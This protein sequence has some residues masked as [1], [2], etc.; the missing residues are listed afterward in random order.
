M[1]NH[2]KNTCVMLLLS[3]IFLLCISLPGFSAMIV[4]EDGTVLNGTIVETT[5]ENVI[6]DTSVGLLEVPQSKIQQILGEGTP[7]GRQNLEP[8]SDNV[9][10]SIIIQPRNDK[11]ERILAEMREEDRAVEEKKIRLYFMLHEKA[12][13]DRM[14]LYEMQSMAGDIPY[15]DRLAMYADFERRDQGVGLGF[16]LFV[17]SLGS[18]LQGDVGGALI[19]DGLLLLGAGLLYWNGNYDYESNSFYNNENGQSN[20]MMYAGI[21]ILAA[22]WVFGIIRPFTYVKKWNR[23]IASSLRISGTRFESGYN[24]GPYDPY[25]RRG[26]APQ[27][28]LE[29][30][31]VEY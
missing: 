15:S 4:L 21:S 12:F 14:G 6:I 28:D 27:I 26:S 13:R 16:N 29:L 24:P 22:D 2:K 20:M 11:T 23:Q 18:W 1:S 10:R 3:S 9:S 30:L 25:S 8:S 7:Q 17:P 5:D 31:S 19:Q